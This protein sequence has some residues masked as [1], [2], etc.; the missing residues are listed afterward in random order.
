MG[1]GPHR[2]NAGT[3]YRVDMSGRDADD[4]PISLRTMLAGVAEAEDQAA[5]AFSATLALIS[6]EVSVRWA[7]PVTPGPGPG[8][9]RISHVPIIDVRYPPARDGKAAECWDGA[10]FEWS[11][12]ISELRD[13]HPG[14]VAF[15]AGVFVPRDSRPSCLD[16]ARWIADRRAEGFEQFHAVRLGGDQLLRWLEVS[17]VLAAGEPIEQAEMVAEWILATFE[18]LAADPPAVTPKR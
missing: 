17:D 12:G 6:G 15:A 18:A 7:D 5:Q 14:E 16:D 10:L 2:S 13:A 9:R 1:D 8:G 4:L 11:F 3:G